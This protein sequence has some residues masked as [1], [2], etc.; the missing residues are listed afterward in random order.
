MEELIDL[1]A[2]NGSPADISDHIKQLLYAKAGQNVEYARPQ[3]AAMMF[4]DDQNYE[5]DDQNY[6][7]DDQDDDQDE[8]ETQGEN[9]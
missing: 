6:E 8:D 2:T 5:A 3:V 9:E 7:A 4:G 1:V